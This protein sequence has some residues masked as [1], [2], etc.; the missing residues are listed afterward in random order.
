[1][2]QSIEGGVVIINTLS[3]KNNGDYPLV[4]AESVEMKNGKNVEDEINEITEN[5]SG[6]IND[7]DINQ[8]STWSSKNIIEKLSM[9]FEV[10]DNIVFCQ[11]IEGT[12]LNI[13]VDIESVQEGE[14]D[15]SP[16][17]VRPI[18]GFDTVNVWRGG[19]NL[20]SSNFDD[21]TRKVNYATYP[22]NLPNG[23]YYISAT[24][25]G[26]PVL[27]TSV[28]VADDGSEYNDFL[29]SVIVINQQGEIGSNLKVPY[30]KT[31][32]NGK[33]VFGVYLT[34]SSD[35]TTFDKIFENYQI[36][37]EYGETATEYEPYRGE[38]FT[39][40]LDQT[41]YGGTLDVGSRM[42]NITHSVKTIESIEESIVQN[43]QEFTENIRYTIPRD[44]L[45]E[46]SKSD[47]MGKSSHFDFM[48][49]YNEDKQHWYIG[50]TNMVIFLP[51]KELTSCDAAGLNEWLQGE[52]E[53]GTPV[54]FQY[55]LETPISVELTPQEILALSGVNTIYS[56]AGNVTVSG[57]PVFRTVPVP[58]SLDEGK[59][60][61][62]VGNE[63]VAMTPGY[64]SKNWEYVQKIVREGK[65][66]Q[67][68]PVGYEFVTHD[69]TEDTDII[70]RVI[71]FDT[72]KAADE[73]LTH[74]MILETKYAYSHKEGYARTIMYGFKDAL[75]YAET[76]LTAGT[77]H[78]TLPNTYPSDGG[79]KTYSFTLTQPVP[80]GGLVDFEWFHGAQAINSLIK[81][82]V[83]PMDIVP[84][85]T[86]S[87]TEGNNGTYLGTADGTS[88]N[89]NIDSRV[90]YGSN[91]YAQGVMRKWLNTA[92][93]DP[94]VWA[95]PETKFNRFPKLPGLTLEN[96]AGF[97]SGLP[98]DF[99]SVVQ[100]AVVP[101]KTN[102]TFE[103]PSLDGTVYELD[104][105]YYTH[106]KFF[107]L[108]TGDI[109]EGYEWIKVLEYYKD[110]TDV[111]RIKY[112]K[113]GTAVNYWL[114]SCHS[115]QPAWSSSILYTGAFNSAGTTNIMAVCPAC[116]IA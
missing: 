79:G 31:V 76:G 26:E 24:I 46:N 95:T 49:S 51:K 103:T 63:W 113:N 40:P 16:E 112:S 71:G 1:M 35:R 7:A 13:M 58:T 114:R 43:V 99:L 109:Q 90:R 94:F 100:T 10:N 56:G 66:P 5:I 78:F 105:I 85:E 9:P 87:L 42:L 2:P 96:R 36:Q 52:A 83:G 47:G 115:T 53:K 97:L 23:T 29:N 59:V 107:L 6:I 93:T 84:I 80:A 73:S 116:I 102:A 3:T 91:N 82:Y 70:W 65:A 32:T 89:M 55:E 98:E 44:R 11:P 33:I 88:A 104:T 12:P 15:P 14:G 75:Y 74:S 48:I 111:D 50:S 101:N 41:V 60:L 106:D 45:F 22:I 72:I 8:N 18:K 69:S 81:T 37:M 28:I 38:T 39:I 30:K 62:V 68:F 67:Y 19:K 4:M 110:A 21:Y 108:H 86:A 34:S 54:Q 64:E 77:Y 57:Y 61:T 17:N 20:F 25:T 92:Q 27:N